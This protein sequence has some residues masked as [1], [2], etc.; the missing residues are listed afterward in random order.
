MKYLKIVFLLMLTTVLVLTGCTR[1]V[2]YEPK[3]PSTDDPLAAIETS[4]PGFID[5]LDKDSLVLAIDRSLRYYDGPGRNRT[6]KFADRSVGAKEM[7]DTLVAFRQV[8]QSDASVEQKKKRIE[9]A[10][11][12]LKASGENGDGSILFTG[13]YEPLLEGSLKR[14]DKYRY[15]L[16]RPPPD[17]VMEKASNNKMKISR[18]VNGRKV[19]YYTRREI[20]VGGVLRGKGLEL[21]WVSDPVELNTLHTQGSGKIRLEDGKILTVS[22]AQNNGRP[23]SSVAHSMLMQNRIDKSDTSYRNFKVW[24]KGKSEQELYEILGVNERYIFFRFVDQEPVGSMGEPVTPARSIATDPDY[25][26]QGALAFIRLR[27]PVFDDNYDVTR[28]INLSR[29]VLNQDKGSAI[30]GPGRVDL[31]CGFGPEAQAT[32]GSLKEKGELY[33]LLLK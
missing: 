28:R 12:M 19:S 29:F 4:R 11:I 15:P 23:F 25:Y 10:F 30:K 1:R 33:F 26:P 32:A 9:E 8:V 3:I 13:Y 17:I 5:D 16:Y 18:T 24:L 31:F 20:D 21:V 6:F 27:K 2:S 14:T 22:Y 7:K